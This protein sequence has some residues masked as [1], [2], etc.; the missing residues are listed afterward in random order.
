MGWK[1]IRKFATDEL[2]PGADISSRGDGFMVL[3]SSAEI[4]P[5]VLLLSRVWSTIQS[6]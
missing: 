5:V 3:G 1:G 2:A 4:G 6:R